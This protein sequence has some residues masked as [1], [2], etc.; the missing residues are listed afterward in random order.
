MRRPA[1]LGLALTCTGVALVAWRVRRR[2]VT[3]TVRGPSMEPALTHGDRV[4]IRRGARGLR[5][6]DIVVV[7]QPDLE[8][9]WRQRPPVTGDL[10]AT[11]W[12]IKRAVALAGDP[13]E[14]APVPPG[15]L[16]AV[17]DGPY[18]DDSRNHGPCPVHQV[19]GVVVRR[20]AR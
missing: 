6:G 3:V 8:T 17:G 2:Y 7:A 15:H 5:R 13:F 9:S 18:S 19:L 11:E 12:F 10:A 1:V 4:L 14:G 20:L 16:A